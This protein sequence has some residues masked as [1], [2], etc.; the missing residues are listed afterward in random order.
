MT[1]TKNTLFATAT[2]AAIVL[3]ALFFTTAT[4]SADYS[5]GGDD[6]RVSNSNSATVINNVEVEAETGDNDAEGGEGDDG[7]YASAR[8]GNATGGNGGRGGNGGSITTGSAIAIGTVNNDV[9]SNDTT[10]DSCGCEDDEPAQMQYRRFPSFGGNNGDDVNVSNRNR[11]NVTNNLEV[12]AETGDNDAEGGEGDDG[13]NARSS[14]SYRGLWHWWGNYGGNATGGNG[15]NGGNG[16]TINTGAAN[17]DG[18]VNNVVNRNVTRVT[19]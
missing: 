6:T 14:S 13:G 9:N 11:A 12:E 7:G 10:V 8:G 2:A 1:T 17:A 3:T 4:A 18:L 16:G 15:G 19:R 5:R